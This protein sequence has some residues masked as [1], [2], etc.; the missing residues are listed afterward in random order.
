[1][2]VGEAVRDGAVRRGWAWW[3]PLPGE[4]LRVLNAVADDRVR[5]DWLCGQWAPHLLDGRDVIWTLRLLV[6]R[7][8]VRL[9]PI[10]PPMLTGRGRVI[11][12]QRQQ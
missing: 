9:R 5:R 6:I 1:M 8:L 7:R 3:G 2:R 11:V 12:A 10:G 4:Q